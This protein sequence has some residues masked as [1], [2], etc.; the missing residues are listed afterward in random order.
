MFAGLAAVCLIG[1]VSRVL[2]HVWPTTA[3]FFNNRLNYP[4][5]YWNAEGM[6]AAMVLVLGF[7]LTADRAQHRSVRVLA[8][9][10]FPAVAATLLLTFSRGAIG[11]V[12]IGL[13]AYCLLTRAQHAADDAARARADHGDRPAFRV[14]CDAAR[15][16][17]SDQPG[18]RVP[19]P[20]RGCGGRQPAC[21]VPV[22]CGQRCCPWIDA[23][24][25]LR[26]C[27]TPPSPCSFVV[28]AVA[29]AILVIAA[30]AVAAGAD[31]FARRE[32]N[33][34][35]TTTPNHASQ[36]RERLTEPANNS[37]LPQWRAAVRIF[38][39]Q[40]LRGPA[41]AP[42]SST[43]FATAPTRPTSPTPTRSTCRAS[44]SSGSSASC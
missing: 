39:T 7:H 28:G 3:S 2:P 41:P 22:C 11:V 42:S 1:L 32:Y 24:G 19:G 29:S 44:P 33:R 25:D 14:G 31:S 30:V 35:V 6:V 15:N 34:F 17:A 20:P 9:A 4:L 43:T 26:L 18:G 13:L 8:A 23:L 38:D 5:T 40:K 36:T 21:W 37:R 10:L 27:G 16:P 12:I